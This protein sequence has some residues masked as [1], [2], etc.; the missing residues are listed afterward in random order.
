MKRTN[1]FRHTVNAMIKTKFEN[2]ATLSKTKI[3]TGNLKRIKENN[4]KSKR[5]K[6]NLKA[7]TT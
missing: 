3:T 6:N 1:T 7:S 5:H 2:A 4:H